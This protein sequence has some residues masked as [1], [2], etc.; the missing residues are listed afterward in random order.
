MR[1]LVTMRCVHTK[2]QQ[3]GANVI[4]G[5]DGRR[6]IRAVVA[7]HIALIAHFVFFADL[8]QLAGQVEIEGTNLSARCAA[9]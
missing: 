1:A 2:T 4:P 5:L 9:V 8:D 6:G 3:G 7:E